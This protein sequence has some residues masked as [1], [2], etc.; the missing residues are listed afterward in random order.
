MVVHSFQNL[1][2][3]A[4]SLEWFLTVPKQTVDCVCFLC[5]DILLL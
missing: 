2:L 3:M 1:D 4:K 5:V